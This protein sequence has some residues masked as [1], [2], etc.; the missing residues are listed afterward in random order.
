M[1][2]QKGRAVSKG[3]QQGLWVPLY[4]RRM[5]SHDVLGILDV[6]P[7]RDGRG[8]S[9]DDRKALGRL[10]AEVGSSIYTAQLRENA[11][12]SARQAKSGPPGACEAP[13]G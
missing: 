3:N 12:L 1:Q 13:A 7:Y 9:S 6:G 8:F 10:G 4:L 2:L 5:R 11:P